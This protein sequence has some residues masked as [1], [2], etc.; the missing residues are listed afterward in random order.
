[1]LGDGVVSPAIVLRRGNATR[2]LIFPAGFK[3]KSFFRR[4]HALAHFREHTRV[5][6]AQED[7]TAPDIYISLNYG[8]HYFEL[9]TTEHELEDFVECLHVGDEGI[10]VD[11]CEYSRSEAFPPPP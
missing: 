4:G 6:F 9:A 2:L 1:M 7:P 10:N 8:R 3:A 5:S 11:P